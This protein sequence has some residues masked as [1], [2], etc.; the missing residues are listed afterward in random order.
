MEKIIIFG[1]GKNLDYLLQAQYTAGFDVVAYCDNDIKKQGAFVNGIEVIVPCKLKDYK[2]DYIYVSSEKYFNTIRWQLISEFGIPSEVIKCFKLRK[3]DGEMGFWKERFKEDGGSF[4]NE[5]YRQLMLGIAQEKD[6]KFLERKI[7]ADFGC[8]PRGSLMW[9]D[10]PLIK[11]GID[12]LAGE[13]L[14]NFGRELIR[15]NMV[16]VTS[17]EDKIPIPDAFCDYVFTINSLDHVDHLQQMMQEIL[18]ILKPGGDILASFNL[19]EPKTACEPQTLTE[20][21]IKTQILES[22]EIVSYR[23]AYQEENDAYA[24]IWKNNFTDIIENNKPGVL[25]VRAKKI[26]G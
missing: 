5:H 9:T 19:N 22:F 13:Y 25:W 8:G 16:Y 21:I 11:L 2:F 3:Y 10:K 18:R 17:S 15:H 14:E 12:V 4:R 1:V 6:D 26:N 23:M 24:N 20:D 7:V